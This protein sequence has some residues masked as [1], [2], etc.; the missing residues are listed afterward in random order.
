MTYRIRKATPADFDAVCQFVSE[1]QEKKFDHHKLQPL[2]SQNIKNPNNIYL[3]AEENSKPVGYAGC[4]LQPLLHH[5]GMVAEI[6]EIYILPEYRNAGIGKMLMDKIKLLA[7]DMGAV[8]LEV[9][10][11]TFRQQAIRFYINQDFEDS[12]KKLVYLFR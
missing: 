12:H 3:I 6:Q 9:T 1:L 10:T 8:Q 7:K 5:Q 2:Y 4:H 11:R